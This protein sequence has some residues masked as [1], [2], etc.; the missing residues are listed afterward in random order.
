MVRRCPVFLITT[1]AI[2]AAPHCAAAQDSA[3]VTITLDRPQTAGMCG[4]RGMW[5]TPIILDENGPT[6]VKDAVVKDRGATAV[7]SPA[8]RGGKPGALAFDALQRSLLVRF[9]DAAEKVAEQINKGYVVQK[10][11]LVLPF[12]DTELWPPGG[13]DFCGPDGYN[14]RMNWGVDALYRSKP[15]QWHA[16]AWALRRAWSADANLGPTYNAYINGA[17]YWTKYG[18]GDPNQD[19]FPKQFAPTEVSWKQPEGRMDVTAV[20]T[21][22]AFGK[23][24]GD[25]LRVL[26]DCGFLV[27]KWE[28]YDHRYFNGVYEWATATGG[29]GIVIK[30]PSLSVTLAKAKDFVAVGRGPTAADIQ[31]LA[32]QLRKKG[33]GGLPTAVM[34]T[35][36]Q[37][38]EWADRF[39]A[40]PDW[41]PAW[42]WQRV[43]ELLAVDRTEDPN[44]PFWFQHVPQFQR[45]RIRQKDK[46]GKF[47]PPDPAMVYRLWIDGIIGRQPRGW[48][49]FEAAKEMTQRYA[50]K[51]AL[52]GPARDAIATYWTAWLMPDRPTGELVHPIFDQLANKGGTGTPTED[53]YFAK[54]G[55]WRGNKS[56]YR[57]G[58]NY[59]ISTQNFNMTASSGAL[60]AGSIIGSQY[61]MADGRHGL[62]HYPLRLW[63][64]SGGSTQEHIDH[65]YYAITLS[66]N[67]AV[68]D[69]GP[70]QPDRLMGHSMLAK[71]IE[72]LASCYHPGLRRIIAGSSRTSLQYLLVTQDGLQHI[73]HTLSRSGA[74]HDLE[75]KLLPG[76]MPAIGHNT[77][78]QAVALQTMTGP[79]AP[80]WAANM[81]DEKPLPFEETSCHQGTWRRAYL[82]R[83][84]GLASSDSS[85]ARID[86]MAQWRR[87]DRQVE[88]MQDLVTMDVRYGVNTTRWANDAGGW[89]APIGLQASMQ[90]RNKLIVV[91]S[92]W[93]A[94]FLR[95]AVAKDGLRS[96]QSSIALFNYQQPSPTW[97]IYADGQRVT[98]L[99]FKGRQGQ[100]ITIKDGVSYLGVIPLPATDLGRTDEVI[101]EEGNEQEYEKVTVKPALVINSYNLRAEKALEKVE[102]WDKIDK[103]CGGFVVEL[104]DVKEYGDFAAFQKHIQEAKLE[105]AYEAGKSL[106]NVTYKSGADRLDLGAYANYQSKDGPAQPFAYRKVNGASPYPPDGI[107]RDTTLVVQGRT[108]R[109]EKNGAV[110][111]SEPNRTTYLQTEPISG[112]YAGFN[113]LPD[114]TDWSLSVP[115]GITVKFDGKIGLA[116]VTVQ[117]NQ[118]NVA[119]DWAFKDEQKKVPGIAKSLLVLGTKEPPKV[120]RN[121][122][123][124]AEKLKTVDADGQAAFVIPLVEP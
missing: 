91:M 87:E 62:E 31:L 98:Q 102:D 74:L 25:R 36:Q 33:D 65:Y 108:G 13:S 51:D 55:D 112:T 9:P 34:P 27:R 67:K 11:E 100:R 70:T 116:R 10:V 12:K 4:F 64:W 60:L 105:T 41:M 122:R 76:R 117:P 5:D 114:L 24:P 56:F 92:P 16:V 69:F 120:V 82:G 109:L 107:D 29:R 99:P 19:R 6:E 86:I 106:L 72:E 123:P 110:L 115:G 111:L 3:P 71:G 32:E 79:W 81:V 118:N 77:T 52:P 58:F 23:T 47:L 75:N 68:A 18:A 46:D 20:L 35:D 63:T 14:Y 15:P 84:Y 42:Q 44:A 90:H 61:A 73:L 121:G 1:L 101:L 119:L 45:N 17:G 40:K 2:L 103:A 85:R 43:Q 53:S 39:A 93:P 28:T 88:R 83:N 38:K 113:P 96:L 97:E 59:T 49:G 8:R 89:I 124:V 26:A 78:P 48:S 50:F 54:T 7:W 21:D 80:E 30:T 57:A 22:E 94:D 104:G 37:L 66:G 95:N